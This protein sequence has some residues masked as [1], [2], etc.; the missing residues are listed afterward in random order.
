MIKITEPDENKS[1]K[2][3]QPGQDSARKEPGGSTI[4]RDS[5]EI[6]L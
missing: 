3:A 4:E 6:D 1:E 5:I 2:D